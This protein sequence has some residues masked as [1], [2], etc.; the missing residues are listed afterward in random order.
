MTP[1]TGGEL[2]MIK[3]RDFSLRTLTP[4][5]HRK[6]GAAPLGARSPMK[7]GACAALPG[8]PRGY[9]FPRCGVR[10]MVVGSHRGSGDFPS[11]VASLRRNALIIGRN[12]IDNVLFR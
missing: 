7:T 6:V 10:T 5:S 1:R 11:R 12:A 9:A 2:S 3:I 4:S 8:G